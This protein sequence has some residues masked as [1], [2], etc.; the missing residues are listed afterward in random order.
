MSKIV[1]KMETIDRQMNCSLSKRELAH[2]QGKHMRWPLGTWV[3]ANTNIGRIWG[4]VSKHWR[5]T[6]YPHKCSID[7]EM[8]IN[9]GDANGSRFSHVLP[10]RSLKMY[11]IVKKEN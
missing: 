5:S 1:R 9:L 10:F 8:P 3:I 6:E 11:R 2:M 4:K 7:F